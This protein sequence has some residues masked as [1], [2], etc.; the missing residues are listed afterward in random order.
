MPYSIRVLVQQMVLPFSKF[1]YLSSG[2]VDREFNDYLRETAPITVERGVGHELSSPDERLGL[3]V[4][5]LLE[6]WM[7]VCCYR[8]FVLPCA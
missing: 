8:V 6:A 3:W 5:I 7:S 2:K 4:R 1:G